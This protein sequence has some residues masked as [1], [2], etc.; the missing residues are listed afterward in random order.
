MPQPASVLHCPHDDDGA[1]L[2]LTQDRRALVGPAA[3]I[4]RQAEPA[5]P[6]MRHTQTTPARTGGRDSRARETVAA[7]S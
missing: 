3:E 7:M 6:R 5:T 1:A 4:S 2:V